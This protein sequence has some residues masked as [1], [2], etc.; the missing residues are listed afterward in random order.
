LA[1]TAAN[2]QADVGRELRRRVKL[3]FDQ[4]GIKTPSSAPHLILPLTVEETNARWRKEEEKMD[5]RTG[6]ETK[7]A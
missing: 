6:G 5:G 1:K 3:A 4:E 2:K 7:R